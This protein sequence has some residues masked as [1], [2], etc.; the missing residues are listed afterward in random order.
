MLEGGTMEDLFRSQTGKRANYKKGELILRSNEDTEDF[1]V[2]ERGL[3]TVYG[4][5][6]IGEKYIHI[7][8]GERE[9]FPLRW[10]VDSTSL[11]LYYE[12]GTDCTVMRYNKKRFLETLHVDASVGFAMLLQVVRQFSVYIARVDN[13]EYKFAQE[14]IAYRLL[15][16]AKR[17]GT[18]KKG[19]SGYIELPVVSQEEIGSAI[20]LSREG[21]SRGLRR[22]KKLGYIMYSDRKLVI[23]NREGLRKELGN[24]ERTL[25][26]D[27]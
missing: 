1:F 15:L 11:N 21:V 22:F 7:V 25:F 17:F 20:N 3:V 24:S 14:R 26:I 16:L 6:N 12:A 8:Y 27:E 5:S 10:L 2:I 18:R 9:V 23:L 13:L 4:I 19:S